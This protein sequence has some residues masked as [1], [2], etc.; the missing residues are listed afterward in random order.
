[1]NTNIKE[2]SDCSLDSDCRDHQLIIADAHVHIYNC[3]KLEEF[4]NSAL[5]NFTINAKKIT[6][7]DNFTSILFLADIKGKEIFNQIK[8]YSQQENIDD[9]QISNWTFH[10]TQEKLSLYARNQN[11]QNI[12]FIAGR[13]IVT[14]ENLEV[15]ALITEQSFEEGLSL[16]VTIQEIIASGGIPVLPWGV[17]KWIGTRGKTLSNLLQNN[18]HSILFLGDNRNRPGFWLRP[19]YFQ[20]AKK[21]GLRIL[22]GTDPLPLASE[23]SRPGSF[24]FMVRG[25]LNYEEPGKHIKQILLDS[26]TNIQAYG[27]LE[28]P[29]RFIRN[30]LAMKLRKRW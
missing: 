20:L 4:L 7:P 30:Q 19:F 29:L 28:S 21:Q 3:F 23:S 25:S 11:N 5:N 22:P 1:M 9:Y 2:D 14:A 10:N 6:S 24:G 16:E 26:K 17:G 13:Q 8:K 12:F 15:L 18:I 27:S